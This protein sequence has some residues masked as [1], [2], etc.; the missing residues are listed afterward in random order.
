MIDEDTLLIVDDEPNVISSLKRLFIDTEY[1][2]L[3]A[4]SGEQGLAIMESRTVDLVISDYRMPGMTGVEFLGQVRDRYPETIR[5]VLSGYADVAAVVEAINNGGVCRFIA[6]PWNDQELL[7]FVMQSFD[8]Y[9]L[10]K[11]NARLYTELQARN[12][13]LE[14]LTRL[15]EEKVAERTRDLEF[16]NRALMVARNI[17]DLL[18]AG[19]LGVDNN[20]IV[21]YMNPAL[22]RF[23]D[24]SR[25]S[26]GL[27]YGGDAAD[28]VLETLKEAVADNKTIFK[29]INVHRNLRIACVPLPSQTGV[30]AMVSDCAAGGAGNEDM[31]GKGK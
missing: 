22:G 17:L 1:N 21:V 13:Q 3:T 31:A 25:L 20:T 23:L 15:L 2:I 8:Q 14:E 9:H 30:I 7:T 10:K 29:V 24:V 26:L 16:K 5:I 19:V 28:P 27:P 6:K 11:E 18:P 12:L 4:E